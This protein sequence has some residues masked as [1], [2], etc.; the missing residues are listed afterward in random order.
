MR[1]E[2]QIVADAKKNGKRNPFHTSYSVPDYHAFD[3]QPWMNC[4]CNIIVYS[5]M[6]AN[7]KVAENLTDEQVLDII[8]TNI[9][10]TSL[11]QEIYTVARFKV[12]VLNAAKKEN[13]EM[14]EFNSARA[15]E[16]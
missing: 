9:S 7:R 16:F 8:I 11:R 14:L 4:G 6:L 10:Q 5:E 12:A 1:T 2:E 13:S 3:S 15:Y